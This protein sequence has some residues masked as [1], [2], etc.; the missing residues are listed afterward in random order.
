VI[1]RFD[2]F[3]NGE[4][5]MLVLGVSGSPRRGGNSET[6]LDE[7]LLGAREAGAQTEKV[8]LSASRISPCM[9]CGACEK[10]GHCIQS[11]DM[12]E[13]NKKIVAA[14]VLIFASPIYFYAVSAWTKIA[15]DRGQEL[16]SRKYILKDPQLM[17]GKRGYCICV[18]ATK[19]ELLFEGAK[20]TMEYYF[21]AAGYKVAGSL[22]VR[23]VDG[24]GDIVKH[25]E[26]LQAARRLGEEAAKTGG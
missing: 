18:G 4:W 25:P 11:D 7:A 6:L 9:G 10:T 12:Q 8:V 19:G 17:I 1:N 24:K 15:I 23:G 22:L 16:W 13:V 20:L 21:D 26:H 14:D 5:F 2:V 3:M